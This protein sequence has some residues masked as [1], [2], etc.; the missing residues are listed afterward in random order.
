MSLLQHLYFRR[1]IR[2]SVYTRYGPPEVVKL[3]EIEKPIPKDKE[4][5]VKVEATT[6]NRTDCGF[7]SSEYLISKF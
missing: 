7:R 2:A 4:V 3:T 6:V 1:T 5:L